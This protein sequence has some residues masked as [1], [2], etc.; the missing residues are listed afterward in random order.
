[1]M[2]DTTQAAQELAAFNVDNTL[3][4]IVVGFAV[5]CVIYGILLTQAWTYFSRFNSDSAIY[6]MLVVLILILETADQVFIGH[7]V[8]FY[9]VTSAGQPLALA[10]GTTIWSVIMQQAAGSVVSTIVK[11]A[12]ATRVYRFSDKNIW[13]TTILILLALGQLGVAVV[14]TVRAFEIGIISK[15]FNLKLVA[16]ISLALGVLTDVLTASALCFFL[17][18]MRTKGRSAANSLIT[19]LVTDAINTGV[20]TT[21]VSLSTLL[22]FDFMEGNLIF[23]ATYF[24]LSKLYAI[25]FLATLNTRRV[26]RGRGTDHEG[27]ASSRRPGGTTGAT[28]SQREVET[29]I[30]ALG[31][32]MP[33][34]YVGDEEA[35]IGYSGYPGAYPHGGGFDDTYD[36]KP[37][38]PAEPK[39]EYEQQHRLPYQPHAI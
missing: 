23:A 13:I 39:R 10:T 20:L 37:G 9:T 14:F 2:P 24:L 31:T 11:C 34:M 33:S 12:F 15:V 36:F 1:M 35:G 30:F 19:R 27:E 32:R 4:A 22:L 28:R 17:W 5:S 18:R 3:G 21:V 25:S 26:I 7:F 16:T 8:Y 29:N 6:K 38:F